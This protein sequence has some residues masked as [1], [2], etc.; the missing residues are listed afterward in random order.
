MSFREI[1]DDLIEG[2]SLSP[3]TM[4]EVFGG[5]MNGEMTPAQVGGFLMALR[6][7]GETVGELTGA[8]RV[9]RAHATHVD[10]AHDVV[11]TC[12]TGGD[13]SGTF[14]IST[15]AALIAAGAGVVVAKHGNRAM[16]GTVGGADV[17]EALGVK[18]DLGPDQVARCLDEAGVAFIFA[19]SF[20][21]A[22]RHVGA[23]RREL[24]VRT[25]FNLLGPL[26]NPASAK[27]QVLGVFAAKW[28]EPLACVLR[29]LGS[30]RALVVHGRDGLDE[31]SL[32]APTIVSELAGGEVTSTEIVPE[33]VGFERCQ[34]E[35]LAG[36]DVAA[37]AAILRAI[38]DGKA[39][40]AQSAISLF[41]AGAAIWIGD[42]AGS[43][44]EGVER[45]RESVQSGAA[46]E[47]LRQLVEVSNR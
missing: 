46:A 24:G 3:E 35:Q 22:M 37:N 31:L 12:G 20:H 17:L 34:P 43:L 5:I 28:V 29:D 6:T 7:K 9:M 18:L 16:S 8:A 25:I 36:G 44:A 47:S 15:A 38:V 42:R 30:R 41:N 33:D 23:I 4:E 39:T 10:T 1:L 40:P 13:G 14:N 19:Q 21:P 26:S 27:R 45:A 11:D 2:R 32:C